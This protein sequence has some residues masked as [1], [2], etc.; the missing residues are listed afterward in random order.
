[1]IT[2]HHTFQRRTHVGWLIGALATNGRGWAA[3]QVLLP[4]LA[5]QTLHAC[6]AGTYSINMT[7][8]TPLDAPLDPCAEPETLPRGSDSQTYR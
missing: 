2:A 6:S 4:Q 5:G 1:M 8:G 7:E 3:P